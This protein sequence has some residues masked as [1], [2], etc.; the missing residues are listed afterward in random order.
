MG[1]TQV[2]GELAL[3]PLSTLKPLKG[4]RE[5]SEL[6]WSEVN[7]ARHVM[8][9]QMIKLGET[10][11]QAEVVDSF[12]EMYEA[13]DAHGIREEDHGDEA[14]A[15][16][17][18]NV[19]REW[20]DTLETTG[21]AWNIGLINEKLLHTIRQQ[22]VTREATAQVKELRAIAAAAATY[23]HRAETSGK[24]RRS[25]YE[26]TT[27][28]QPSL[29]QPRKRGTILPR[30]RHPLAPGEDGFFT[31]ALRSST[32]PPYARSA[33]GATSTISRRAA[34]DCSGMEG[35]SRGQN[36]EATRNSPSQTGRVC[37]SS[38]KSRDVEANNTPR[39]T[40]AQAAGVLDMGLKA[41][42]AQRRSRPLTPYKVE[43][44]KRRI[45]EFSLET[46]YRNVV[47]GL[48]HG[49]DLGVPIWRI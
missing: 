6:S 41:V 37:V 7:Q 8:I 10:I 27:R 22:I 38:G 24:R 2:N 25:G 20:H 1:I 5:D 47:D 35:P 14:V 15:E 46:R 12:I 29:R 44:W 31:E 48:R 43:S 21:G 28:R 17:Q 16:Y 26:Y 30:R 11:W 45:R 33:L 18:A 42:L 13:L 23:Q 34:A 4:I 40:S 19:R 32:A 36:G 9:K 3:Q 49:F 39:N